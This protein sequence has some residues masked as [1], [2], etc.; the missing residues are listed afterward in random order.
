MVQGDGFEPSK[1]TRQIYSLI[2]LATREPLPK[3]A[4]IFRPTL[5]TVN[6]FFQQIHRL[7][8]H[9]QSKLELA[10]GIEPPTG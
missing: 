6:L 3:T 9:H 10:R 5:L 1:L 2:P 8:K 7:T 4:G